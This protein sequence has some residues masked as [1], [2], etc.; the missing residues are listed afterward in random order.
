MVRRVEEQSHTFTHTAHC[1]MMV[2]RINCEHIPPS[3]RVV[4]N[5]IMYAESLKMSGRYI[6]T[7]CSIEPA[8]GELVETTRGES[9]TA[10]SFNYIA[11]SIIRVLTSSEFYGAFRCTLFDHIMCLISL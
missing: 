4:V 3:T 6:R 9:F 10:V 5:E 2:T 8:T 1:H 11:E 7:G